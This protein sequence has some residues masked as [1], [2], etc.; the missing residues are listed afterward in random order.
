M[1]ILISIAY[2]VS[3]WIVL[4]RFKGPQVD[5]GSG[6]GLMAQQAISWSIVDQDISVSQHG[7]TKEA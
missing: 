6:N 3:N 7:V 1:P 2:V 5:F 4:V